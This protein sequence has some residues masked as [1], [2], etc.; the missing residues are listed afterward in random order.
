MAVQYSTAQLC[1]ASGKAVRTVFDHIKKGY[2][3]PIP[4]DKLPPG[5]AGHRFYPAE[6]RKWLERFPGK[7]L[8]V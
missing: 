8:P 4:K 7:K 6:A 1:E 3:Q 5:I 2:L